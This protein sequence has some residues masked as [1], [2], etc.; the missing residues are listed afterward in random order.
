MISAGMSD[1]TFNWGPKSEAATE[2]T[3]HNA[4]INN[5]SMPANIDRLGNNSNLGVG[6]QSFERRPSRNNI[7]LSTGGDASPRG[8]NWI[9]SGGGRAEDVVTQANGNTGSGANGSMAGPSN[10]SGAAPEGVTSSGWMSARW[11]SVF[12]G[13][14]AT[15]VVN[16]ERHRKFLQLRE[17]ARQQREN[18]VLE[19]SHL[20]KL[21]Y[22]DASVSHVS[23]LRVFREPT[24]ETPMTPDPAGPL[25]PNIVVS[26]P[27]NCFNASST[28]ALSRQPT[29]QPQSPE[30]ASASGA[31]VIDKGDFKNASNGTD[32]TNNAKSEQLQSV[33]VSDLKKSGNF[34][35]PINKTLA[36]L[37]VSENFQLESLPEGLVGLK[38]LNMSCTR[39]SHEEHCKIKGYT[40]LEVLVGHL[41]SSDV[42]KESKTKYRQLLRQR[43]R[44]QR[45]QH[46][47]VQTDE[48]VSA[49]VNNTGTVRSMLGF[50]KKRR[51]S[52]ADQLDGSFAASTATNNHNRTETFGTMLISHFVQVTSAPATPKDSQGV[53]SGSIAFGATL[54]PDANGRKYE[55]AANDPSATDNSERVGVQRSN[56]TAVEHNTDDH[57][58]T[59]TATGDNR[60]L[61]A[62]LTDAKGG[63]Q[64]TIDATPM[65]SKMSKEQV[66]GPTDDRHADTGT[67]HNQS[68][69]DL[70]NLAKSG[71][72]VSSSLMPPA[73][74]ITVPD[75]PHHPLLRLPSSLKHLL[76]SDNQT[77]TDISSLLTDC[78]NLLSLDLSG[79][80][81][82]YKLPNFIR[83]NKCTRG[84]EALASTT[85]VYGRS[86]D[87][88]PKVSSEQQ[89][90][91]DSTSTCI[92]I[93]HSR[94]PTMS[95]HQKV[96]SPVDEDGGDNEEEGV[97]LPK[98]L[99][100]T[101]AYS[102]LRSLDP[103][104]G[105]PSL[106]R[107]VISYSN[108]ITLIPSLP[109][110]TTLLASHC[111]GLV[112]LSSLHGHTIIERLDVSD[113][114]LVAI[115]PIM[116]NIRH[117]DISHTAI[118]DLLPL[119]QMK[120]RLQ[121]L[122]IA[123][124][125]PKR[126]TKAQRLE[127]LQQMAAV[128]EEP[129]GL[130]NT[131]ILNQSVKPR[132]LSPVEL[133]GSDDSDPWQ[134]TFTPV[135][136]E[137]PYLEVMHVAGS[138][139]VENVRADPRSASLLTD[140]YELGSW[141][142]V[143]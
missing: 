56:S 67:A 142:A 50:D 33:F 134:T 61:N 16:K 9:S 37:N 7:N 85:K 11:G 129:R 55:A 131:D 128:A 84:D 10:N 100:F 89:R 118:N 14:A 70:T 27:S 98:L 132:V 83:R 97:A 78:P 30:S 6:P 19:V 64:K 87:Q 112:D 48:A 80:A 71:K 22:L 122:S 81:R 96:V 66:D 123:G 8:A 28:V 111:L 90:M 143:M 108:H 38:Y 32:V 4:A 116:P 93:A 24:A 65:K 39:L 54:C 120:S 75:Y 73:E 126:A 13:Q 59:A 74:E 25:S 46:A 18:T 17:L 62:T 29:M 113:S 31:S 125:W 136:E 141:C 23:H 1:A 106:S 45:R 121:F 68:E 94:T 82:L 58:D 51:G 44:A 130:S 76:L 52:K 101:V 138:A 69:N 43:D 117:L 5:N 34:A 36:F 26:S 77:V 42:T 12:G 103:M 88:L 115:L 110:L 102:Q 60:S 109:N 53:P 99:S 2:G 3:P 47:R 72:K 119:L 107:L 41:S 57:D 15:S 91:L 127:A 139:F 86:N 124:L 137:F 49:S 40:S 105:H 135:M 20:P 79:A 21:Q 104:V 133:E 95:S 140:V 35:G 63:D 114:E 92:S